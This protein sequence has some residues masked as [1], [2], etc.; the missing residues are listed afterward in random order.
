MAK[1]VR[2]S[3]MRLIRRA[4]AEAKPFDQQIETATFA[5][6]LSAAVGKTADAK[7]AGGYAAAASAALDDQAR[8]EIAGALDVLDQAREQ[9]GLRDWPAPTRKR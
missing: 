2:D 6:F 7:L 8:V 3:A 5:A 9:L 1:A 4:I